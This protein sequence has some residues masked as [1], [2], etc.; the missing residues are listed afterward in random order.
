M[1]QAI[2]SKSWN[3]HPTKQQVYGHLPPISKTTQIRWTRHV[4]YCW[5][6]K[7]K[8]I[9]DVLVLTLSHEL[10]RDGWLTRTY[11]QELSMDTRCCLEDLLE[12]MDDRQMAREVQGN[13]CQQH[14]TIYIRN[15]KK[16]S[17]Y[18]VLSAS[19]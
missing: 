7:D 9:S 8:L 4:G 1:L 16:E 12:A 2:L 10:A 13:P 15:A 5:R 14:D 11:L 17:S 6:N 19:M 18:K 3:Q